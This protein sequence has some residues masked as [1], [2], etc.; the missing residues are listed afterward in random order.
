MSKIDTSTY[1]LAKSFDKLVKPITTIKYTIQD[2][3]WFSKEFENY[4]MNTFDV[5][6]L[7]KNIPRTETICLC[8]KNVYRKQKHI[9]SLSKLLFMG[10]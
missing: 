1:K 7:F 9:D 4:V 6:P 10:Y 2:L 8:V 5:K 3:V